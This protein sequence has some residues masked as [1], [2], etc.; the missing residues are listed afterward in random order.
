MYHGLYK[1]LLF[2]VLVLG[3]STSGTTRAGSSV[4]KATQKNP[5]YQAYH[6]L[7]ES[8]NCQ[9][10]D[11]SSS[12][13]CA[14]FHAYFNSEQAKSYGMDFAGHS[15]AERNLIEAIGAL[16]VDSNK[17]NPVDICEPFFLSGNSYAKCYGS[18]FG[19]LKLDCNN[20]W[21][22]AD[23]SLRKKGLIDPEILGADNVSPEA[24]ALAYHSCRSI[25]IAR[26]GGSCWLNVLKIKS[27]LKKHWSVLVYDRIHTTAK[28]M[29]EYSR[30]L[31]EGMKAIHKETLHSSKNHD[32]GLSRSKHA[33]KNSDRNAKS[34]APTNSVP[35]PKAGDPHG[36]TQD[37]GENAHLAQ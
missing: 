29:D 19:L 18:W 21:K 34:L 27:E 3:L 16:Q 10:V 25:E 12:E 17:I 36:T 2:G 23:R 9:N 20:I 32:S 1:G 30:T 35:T 13:V 33:V 26:K 31:C 11:W 15:K 6:S 4:S 24:K 37:P 7:R 22:K 14:T 8:G 5:V 28:K